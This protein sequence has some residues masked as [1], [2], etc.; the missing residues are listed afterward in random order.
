[1][2]GWYKKYEKNLK[3]DPANNLRQYKGWGLDVVHRVRMV[4]VDKDYVNR[5]IQEAGHTRKTYEGPFPFPDGTT[6]IGEF[7]FK[8][9][10]G[11]KGIII[12]DTVTK[13][14]RR[15]FHICVGLKDVGIPDSVNEI[16]SE[17]FARCKSLEQINLSKTLTKIDF[18]TFHA[19]D[20]L[21]SIVI[22]EGVEIIEAFALDNCNALRA[23]NLPS[24]LKRVEFR[25]F[26][27]HPETKLHIE[28]VVA[29]KSLFYSTIDYLTESNQLEPIFISSL[30]P[31][32]KLFLL[33]NEEAANSE[34]VIQ[35]NFL[36]RLSGPSMLRS[37]IDIALARQPIFYPP[38]AQ[39]QRYLKFLREVAP[40]L[41][42]EIHLMIID[43]I[44]GN[45]TAGLTELLKTFDVSRAIAPAGALYDHTV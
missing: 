41:P 23:V 12:P 3:S 31:S 5:V 14:G 32:A 42:D 29:P 19:C 37:K 16:E 2:V 1:M 26:Y 21:V 36:P 28:F 38:L 15:A 22:P 27:K 30:F 6:E 9:C 45:V 10:F 33:K 7:A 35:G 44:N 13:I 40:G 24:T 25:A 11:L 18:A 34:V 20:S 39:G 17:A 8:R 4:V 43:F